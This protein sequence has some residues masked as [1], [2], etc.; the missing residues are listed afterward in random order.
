[1]WIPLSKSVALSIMVAHLITFVALDAF[2]SISIALGCTS[3]N[4]YT[5]ALNTSSS[6]VSFC[7]ACAS[8]DHYSTPLSSSDFSM[9]TKSIGV[10]F[11]PTCSLVLQ[12][13]LCLRKNSTIDL[14]NLYI[15]WII[16]CAYCI[17]SLYYF[18]SSHSKD[19]GECDD[20]FIAN[21]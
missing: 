13:L 19:D 18:S 5:L 10:V 3:V 21:G 15:S 12:P 20:N 17:F 14:P 7:I 2:M 8:I 6:F 9:Y 16:E 11:G 1:M 4:S